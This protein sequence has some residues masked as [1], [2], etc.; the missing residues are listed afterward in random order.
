MSDFGSEPQLLSVTIVRVSLAD[1][2]STKRAACCGQYRYVAILLT[3]STA[4]AN[5]VGTHSS[6]TTDSRK[7]V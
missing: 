5:V 4:R 7:P 1:M 6:T 3:L 2:V